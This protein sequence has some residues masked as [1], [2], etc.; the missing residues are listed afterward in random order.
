MEEVKV[1]DAIQELDNT[2]PQDNFNNN[3]PSNNEME[4]AFIK[5]LP[6]WD[7]AP[8]YEVVRRVNRK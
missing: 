1:D 7:L 6:D 8:M 5:G 4:D 2:L 3:T